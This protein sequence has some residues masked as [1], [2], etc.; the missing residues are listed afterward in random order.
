MSD[1]DTCSREVI[2]VDDQKE[3]RTIQIL[4]FVLKT[5]VSFGSACYEKVVG[6][7][8]LQLTTGSLLSSLI[9]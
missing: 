8:L 3:A 5:V 9:G 1:L 2:K 4:V 6:T 7:S